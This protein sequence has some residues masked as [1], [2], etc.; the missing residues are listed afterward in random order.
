[1]FFLNVFYILF[2]N[3]GRIYILTNEVNCNKILII[4]SKIRFQT[5][6]LTWCAT[7]QNMFTS[8]KQV[9]NLLVDTSCITLDVF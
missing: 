6:Y 3:K 4:F 9:F 7:N 8:Y 1:M 2:P 5:C